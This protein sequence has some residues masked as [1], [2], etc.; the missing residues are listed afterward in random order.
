MIEFLSLFLADAV[1]DWGKLYEMVRSI[2]VSGLTGYRKH[3]A[4][5][6]LWGIFTAIS[7]IGIQNWN[8]CSYARTFTFNLSALFPFLDADKWYNASYGAFMGLVILAVE[9]GLPAYWLAPVLVLASL[10]DNSKGTRPKSL[11][12]ILSWIGSKGPTVMHQEKMLINKIHEFYVR[13]MV[14]QVCVTAVHSGLQ[15]K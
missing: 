11:S 6:L 9:I 12:R 4:A 2:R 1:P 5:F 3:I 10:L 7:K 15:S 13:A 8:D 14:S